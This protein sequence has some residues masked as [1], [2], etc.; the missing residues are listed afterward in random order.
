MVLWASV[1]GK[2]WSRAFWSGQGRKA[3]SIIEGTYARIGENHQLLGILSDGSRSI[4]RS[5]SELARETHC[6]TVPNAANP[7]AGA[8]PRKA[9]SGVVLPFRSAKEQDRRNRSI[10]LT[11]RTDRAEGKVNRVNQVNTLSIALKFGDRICP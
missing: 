8:S 7:C 2:I 3:T 9:I 11:D 1:E 5:L 10:D 6:R 4:L